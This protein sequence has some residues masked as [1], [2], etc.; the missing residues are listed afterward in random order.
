ML[1]AGEASYRVMPG[2]LTRVGIKQHTSLIASQLGSYSKD[3]WVI[4]SEPEKQQLV[5]NEITAHVDDID[6]ADLP[7]RVAENLFWMGRYLERAD[8]LLRLMRTILSYVLGVAPLSPKLNK[9]FIRERD[10]AKLY[11]SRLC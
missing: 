10:S 6:R 1:F 5:F 2:G 7:T 8:S 4:A 3:T 11:L 9:I